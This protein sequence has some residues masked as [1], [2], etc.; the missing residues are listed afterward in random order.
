MHTDL[1]DLARRNRIKALEALE[2]RSENIFLLEDAKKQRAR[3]AD[4]IMFVSR[5]DG[6]ASEMEEFEKIAA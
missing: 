1:L 5:R 3:R 4:A 6:A 2:Q